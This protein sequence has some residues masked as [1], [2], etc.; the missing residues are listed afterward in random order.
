MSAAAN[1]ENNFDM[2]PSALVVHTI[3]A[4]ECQP[5]SGLCR[6]LEVELT[7]FASAPPTLLWLWM[8]APKASRQ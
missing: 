8:M 3:F 2:D 5:L 4:D 6:G 7:E 1:A